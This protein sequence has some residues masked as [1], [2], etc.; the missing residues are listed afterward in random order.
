[1][2]VFSLTRE[3]VDIES[4]TGNEMKV[5]QF[6]YD[7]LSGLGYKVCR[8][9]V[10]STR[11][12]VLALPPAN[13]DPA[14]VLSTHMD[15]VPPYI[16]SSEDN[17]R[18]Y[19]RGSCDAKGIIAAQIGAAERLR[20]EGACVGL[21]F[22]VGE[23]RDN[24]GAKAA[25]RHP[26]RSKFLI[27]GEPT[28]NRLAVASKGALHVE[29]AAA[30]RM[31]HSG[32]PEHGD[33]AIDKLLEALL[34]LR[35]MNLPANPT[36]GPTTMNIG[37]IEGGRALNV[38]ADQASANL[39]FRT[40]GPTEQLRKQILEAVGTLARVV[41][42]TEVPF[43]ELSSQSA[44][45]TMVASFFTDIPSL[46]NWGKPLLIGPGCIHVAH[47]EHEHIEKKQLLAGM[48]AYFKLAKELM[49]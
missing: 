25:N 7:H 46:S 30:G 44:W 19:G 42:V 16:P 32:Y 35:T 36:V 41:F 2:N 48:D 47:T 8:I 18:I 33:S 23:E 29:I 4:I 38:I 14:V 10:E 31:A 11:F 12:N 15:T 28:E 40:T 1:M 6:L 22:L 13:N 27:N 5:G 39:L 24:A 49:V 45:P 26:I 9:P 17:E 43:I 34:R 21:L 20:I 3:L 37:L